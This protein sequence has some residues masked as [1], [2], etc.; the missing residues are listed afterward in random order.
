[1]NDIFL[2]VLINKLILHKDHRSEVYVA[3]IFKS[4]K[5]ITITL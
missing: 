2:F 3:I 5:A 1:M 4:K